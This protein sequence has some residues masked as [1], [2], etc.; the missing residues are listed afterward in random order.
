[1]S[2]RTTKKQAQVQPSAGLDRAREMAAQIRPTA[3]G[4]LSGQANAAK[5]AATGALA[6]LTPLAKSAGT[7]ASQ[8]GMAA[9]QGVH[10]AREWAAPRIAQGAHDAREWA[11]PRIAQGAHDAREWAAPKIEQAGQAISDTV[12]PKVAEVITGTVAP[13]VTEVMTATAR[14]IEPARPVVARRRWPWLLAGA[15]GAGALGAVITTVLRRRAARV[16]DDIMTEDMAQAPGEDD[17]EREEVIVE[18]EVGANGDGP[19]P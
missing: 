8:A 6:R 1:M 17:A 4:R 5:G 10:D 7:A 18:A 2:L 3:V 16:Q 11:A 9:T 19:T 12:A 13:R 14:R 15:L